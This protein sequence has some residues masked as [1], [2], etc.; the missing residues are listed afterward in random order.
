MDSPVASGP[1][2]CAINAQN[3]QGFIRL[4]AV[5][6]RASN[7]PLDGSKRPSGAGQ[8]SLFV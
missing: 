4:G 3:L 2:A 7:R 5:L 1:S 8:V 6:W